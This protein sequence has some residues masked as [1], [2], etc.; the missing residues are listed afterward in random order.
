MRVMLDT[1][2]PTSAGVFAGTRIA[3]LILFTYITDELLD[4]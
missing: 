1:N 4:I 3:E 2:I